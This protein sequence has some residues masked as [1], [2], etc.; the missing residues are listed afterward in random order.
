MPREPGSFQLPPTVVGVK[1]CLPACLSACPWD[2]RRAC[3]STARAVPFGVL[4]PPNRFTMSGAL[5][6]P[7]PSPEQCSA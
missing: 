2:S 1:P 7:D 6:G 5:R 3:L 4:K